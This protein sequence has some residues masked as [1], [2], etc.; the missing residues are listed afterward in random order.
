MTKCPNCEGE[1]RMGGCEDEMVIR[2]EDLN[3]PRCCLSCGHPFPWTL[4]FTKGNYFE[5]FVCN[6]FPSDDFDVVHATTATDDLNGRRIGEVKDPDF[7]FFHKSSGRFFW[8]ECKFRTTLY[9][10]KIKWAEKWQMEGYQQF[11][12]LHRPE[13]V[14]VVIGFGGSP[15]NPD[16]LYS[17][18][19]DEI[20]SPRLSPMSIDKYSR[21]VYKEFEYRGGR[22]R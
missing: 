9:D 1:I 17:I 6:L 12:R 21:S 15:T 7:R 16:G 22:L 14:Y 10:G 13:K 5:A 3:L 11:Q 8:V 20:T 18:P 2:M 4:N 19:L